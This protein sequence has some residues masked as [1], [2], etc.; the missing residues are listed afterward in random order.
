[1]LRHLA[2]LLL[3]L[4]LLVL[5]GMLAARRGVRLSVGV[6]HHLG[7]ERRGEAVAG[8]ASVTQGRLP[9]RWSTHY[10]RA[11]DAAMRAGLLARW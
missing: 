5:L 4:L 11:L 7:R 6:G 8:G 3:L 9:V 10:G 1:M 2:A